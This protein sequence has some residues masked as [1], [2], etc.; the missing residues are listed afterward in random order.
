[1]ALCYLCFQL[2]TYA[3]EEYGPSC[4]VEIR[5]AKGMVAYFVVI[6]HFVKK[7]LFHLFIQVNIILTER[8]AAQL[9]VVQR[10]KM[11]VT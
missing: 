8:I 1:M 6:I 2:P 4:R 5:C 3:V 9:S 10:K 7:S 11:S